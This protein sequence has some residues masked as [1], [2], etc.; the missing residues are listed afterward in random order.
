MSSIIVIIIIM[1]S[2][3]LCFSSF[4][5][6]FT[7]YTPSWRA[8]ANALR[9][10]HETPYLFPQ[11]ILYHTTAFTVIPS[12]LHLQLHLPHELHVP[13]C[14]DFFC[15]GFCLRHPL[16][17]RAIFF[18]WASC[19]AKER[20]PYFGLDINRL[21]RMFQPLFFLIGADSRLPSPGGI[22]PKLSYVIQ[23]TLPPP[24]TYRAGAQDP[25]APCSHPSR[26][27]CHHRMNLPC[28]TYSPMRDPKVAQARP[29]G[30]DGKKGRGE[31]NRKRSYARFRWW[32]MAQ[33]AVMDLP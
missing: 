20:K 17:F 8:R 32:K 13:G 30:H 16:T 14:I 33:A 4:Y 7:S 22:G 11:N 2:L 21:I 28:S 18:S 23:N 31:G 6:F 1:A 19:L 5:P 24:V 3:C 25:T 26:T 27:F 29:R 12:H 15:V 9:L 10:D